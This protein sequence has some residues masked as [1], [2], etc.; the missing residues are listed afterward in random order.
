MAVSLIIR[1]ASTTSWRS[2]SA[3]SSCCGHVALE[4]LAPGQQHLVGR[5]AA[6]ALAAHAV[7]HD[8]QRAALARRVGMTS[9]WSCW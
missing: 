4:D 6:A 5:L 3:A 7:G 8:G 9:T 1:C 2:S